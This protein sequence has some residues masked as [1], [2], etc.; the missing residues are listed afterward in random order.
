MGINIEIKDLM[1]IM[2]K[3]LKKAQSDPRQL[4]LG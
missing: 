3:K 4:R 2:M 1:S